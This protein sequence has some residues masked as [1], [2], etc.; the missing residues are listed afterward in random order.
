M[1][2]FVY[3]LQKPAICILYIYWAL[4]QF[5]NGV[6]TSNMIFPVVFPDIFFGEAL[7]SSQRAQRSGEVIYILYVAREKYTWNRRN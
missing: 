7:Y 3:N 4:L 6:R 1:N 2:Y 5:K